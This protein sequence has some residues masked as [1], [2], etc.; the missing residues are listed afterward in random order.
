MHSSKKENQATPAQQFTVFESQAKKALNALSA[1]LAELKQELDT[2]SSTATPAAESSSAFETTH[3]SV[4]RLSEL[5][6]QTS[7]YSAY[8][9]NQTAVILDRSNETACE[10]LAS[11]CKRLDDLCDDVKKMAALRM[12]CEEGLCC[13]STKAIWV[14]A[15]YV[16]RYMHMLL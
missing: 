6:L 5:F 12:D 7:Y 10:F 2:M 4:R 11:R 8:L 14:P 15:A 3:T 13:H 1:T 9:G 16:E